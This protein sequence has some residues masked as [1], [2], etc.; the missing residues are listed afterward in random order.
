MA[1]S[2]TILITCVLFVLASVITLTVLQTS[3]PSEFIQMT[4]GKGSLDQR[5]QIGTL[6]QVRSEFFTSPGATFTTYMYINV[7]KPRRWVEKN[8]AQRLAIPF[9]SETN[10]K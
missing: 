10:V 6:D 4:P 2:G 5:I 7:S 9:S 8:P 1:L 3:R